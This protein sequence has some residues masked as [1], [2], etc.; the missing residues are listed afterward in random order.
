MPFKSSK[1]TYGFPKDPY[2]KELIGELCD[3]LNCAL[4]FSRMIVGVKLFYSQEEYDA[5]SWNEPA[6]PLSYCCIVEKATRGMKFKAKLEHLNCDGGTTALGLEPSNNRIESGMEYF[7]YNLYST[8]A[9]A[10]RVRDGVPGLYRSSVITQ[11]IAVAPLAQF[12]FTPDVIIFM[13]NPYQAMRIQQGYVYHDG[14]RIEISGASMQA[15]CAEATVEPY[16]KGRLNLTPLCPSTRFLA[17][18]KDEEMAVGV[19]FEKFSNLVEG[20]IATINTT[21]IQSRKDEIK[22]RFKKK[23]IDF[24]CLD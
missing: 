18:W 6:A 15:L 12:D 3:D 21:D 20:V 13:V 22:E 10:K 16:L 2:N 7:S 17:K 24:H 8:P 11:G 5:L 23:N 1:F 9:A 14:G 19:P 4:N